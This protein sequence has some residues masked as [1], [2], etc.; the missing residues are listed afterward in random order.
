MSSAGTSALDRP[1]HRT[2]G[3]GHA[4]SRTFEFVGLRGDRKE[5]VTDAPALRVDALEVA[6]RSQAARWREA[7]GTRGR[8]PRTRA[9]CYGDR[10]LRPL[11]RLRAKTARPF[12]VAMR[13]RNP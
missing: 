12:F 1:A 10:R 6:R 7:Q 9:H 3:D 8:G 5:I 2:H 4:Q 13:A 11:A